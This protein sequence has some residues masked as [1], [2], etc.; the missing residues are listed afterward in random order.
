[1]SERKF[2]FDNLFFFWI[3]LWLRIWVMWLSRWSLFV[4]TR[5]VIALFIDRLGMIRVEGVPLAGQDQLFLH[6]D[7]VW[8][9]STSCS[10]YR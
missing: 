2:R 1:M 4:K 5:M 10:G 7:L 6:L 9:L 3:V 8:I